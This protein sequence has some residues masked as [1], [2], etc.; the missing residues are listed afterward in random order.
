[1]KTKNAK[2][3]VRM[4]ASFCLLMTVLV[5]SSMVTLATSVK[6]VGELIITGKSDKAVTVNGE[7]A[8]TGRTIFSSSTISTPDGMTAILDLGKAGKIELAPNT[9]FSLNAGETVKGDLTAGNAKVL[10]SDNTI[11]VKTL[12]GDT[13]DLNAG[14]TVSA[15]SASAAKSSTAASGRRWVWFL[16][17]GVATVA[18]V[19]IALDNDDDG[20]QASPVR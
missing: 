15:T 14:D 13:V 1:M 6:P 7:P 12:T 18:I 9:T 20:P 17:F 4:I 11:A 3:F 2:R 8:T 10:S 16:I 5:S 19:W